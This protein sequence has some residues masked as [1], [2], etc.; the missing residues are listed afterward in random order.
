MGYCEM[1]WGEGR[2]MSSPFPP[3]IQK[4]IYEEITDY[5]RQHPEGS[6]A[7]A[8]AVALGRSA[9]IID[10]WLTELNRRDQVWG[11]KV[12]RE[13]AEVTLWFAIYR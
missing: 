8:I 6:T 13:Q 10:F 11:F 3:R 2:R 7:S 1:Y 5:L 4:R 12:F 9:Q